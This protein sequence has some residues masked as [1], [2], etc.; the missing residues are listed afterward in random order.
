VIILDIEIQASESMS[1]YSSPLGSNED[2]LIRVPAELRQKLGLETGLFLCLKSK[3]GGSIPLQV[4]LAY[5]EDAE[6]SD[7]CAYV[8]E[9]TYKQLSIRKKAVNSLVKP[10]DDI[11]IGADPEFFLVD[12]ITGGNI[13]AGHF[14]PH[15]GEV[16]SDCG[17]AELRPRPGFNE[18]EVTSNLNALMVK[19]YS[20][21]SA[22][23]LYKNREIDMIAASMLNGATAGFHVHFGLPQIFLKGT[24][25]SHRILQKMVAV[26]DYYIGIPSILPEGSEDFQRRSDKY[27]RYGKPGDHRAD[28]LTLEYRVPGGHLLRHPLLTMGILGISTVTIKDLLSRIKAYS[29]D[30]KDIYK[31]EK[32]KDMSN[33]YPRLPAKEEVYHSMVS[34]KTDKA[35]SHTMSIMEDISNMIG[36]KDRSKVIVDYFDYILAYIKH[37]RKFS[38][39][40]AHNWRLKSNER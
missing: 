20:H 11:L 24:S 23:T 5:I 37:G 34:H 12:K 27:S 38:E 30:Y 14:F 1:Q 32:H 36:Y 15:Y 26:L 18:Y 22:R 21:L 3:N 10:A 35:I 9:D 4:A 25:E 28:E 8:S 29:N 2:R 6:K 40:I 39:N 19:A 33:L 13:S 7:G 17:L 16:G 31:I